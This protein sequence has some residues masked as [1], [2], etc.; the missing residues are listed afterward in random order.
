MGI[1]F[2]LVAGV[3]CAF[4]PAAQ[5]QGWTATGGGDHGG[6]DWSPADGT[7]VAGVHTNVGLF[8]VAGGATVR[9]QPWDGTQFGSFQVTANAILIS[10]T[11]SANGAGYGGGA[12]GSNDSCCSSGQ[13]GATVGVGGGGGNGGPGHWGCGGT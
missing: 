9:V 11:L 3:V 8:S 4:A 2:I 5:A 13:T 7:L 10:G 1:T 6:Q 12:G